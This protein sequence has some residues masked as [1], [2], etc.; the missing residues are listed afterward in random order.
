[1]NEHRH[2]SFVILVF[3]MTFSLIKKKK[4]LPSFT[5]KH[6]SSTRE[7]HKLIKRRGK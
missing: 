3:F 4:L 5:N 2:N 7:A 1:M 6:I